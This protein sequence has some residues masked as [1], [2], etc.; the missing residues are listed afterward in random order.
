MKFTVEI[1]ALGNAAFIESEGSA[2]VELARILVEL[3]SRLRE[4][5]NLLEEGFDR[6]VHDL[7]GNPVGQALLR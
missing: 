1:T 4:T 2:G 5:P 3:A 7:Y 6:P